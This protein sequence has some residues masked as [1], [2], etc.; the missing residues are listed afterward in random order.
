MYAYL[1]WSSDKLFPKPNIVWNQD[2]L[3]KQTT[4]DCLAGW[5]V[6]QIDRS[7][8]NALLRFDWMLTYAILTAA[9]I[10]SLP[11]DETG[12]FMQNKIKYCI[13]INYIVLP[14]SL[15]KLPSSL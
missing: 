1:I 5:H 14:Y 6:L 12:F 13:D 3:G 9:F 15:H 10:S 2:M 4:V 7:G 11:L 8:L